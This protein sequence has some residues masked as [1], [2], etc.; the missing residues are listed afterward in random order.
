MFH[1]HSTADANDPTN[2]LSE[3]RVSDGS[4]WH[5]QTTGPAKF[6]LFAPYAAGSTTSFGT[7][8]TGTYGVPTIGLSGWP[9]IGS[10]ID[11]WLDNAPYRQPALLLIGWPIPAG[12]SFPFAD[13]YVTDEVVLFLQTWIH[14]S[15]LSGALSQSFFVPNAP[16]LSG[17]QLSFQFGVFD[18]AATFGLSHTSA[19]TATLQ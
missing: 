14:T 19:M 6:R 5:A 11:V 2:V 4:T 10:P 7:G 9:A 17:L 12:L 15:P 3:I 1:Q 8:K 16:A 18:P 13:I